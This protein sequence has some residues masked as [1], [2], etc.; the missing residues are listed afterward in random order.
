MASLNVWMNGERVGEWGTLRGGNPF[1]R[2]AKS[3][4]DSSRARA[5]SISL[6]L[7]ADLE[8][9]GE[10]VEN[11]FENLL[12]DNPEIRRRIRT[13]FKTSSSST[14][15][16]LAAI[17]R[18]CAG[19]VQLV[20]PNEEPTGWNRI[21]AELLTD[22]EV[23]T[24]LREVTAGTSLRRD[25]EDDFRMSLAGAQEKTAFLGMAGKWFRPRHATPTTHIFKL[26]L[27]VIGGFRGDFSD[28]VE[29]EWLCGKILH[30]L[31]LPVAES[32][33]GTFGEQRVL[34]VKRFDRR[35][36]GVAE[37]AERN[38]QYKPSADHW[39]ARLP[40]EDFCQA[41]GR[42]STRKY[43]AD[44]GP[45]IAEILTLL[46]FSANAASDQAN[47]VLAQ[48]TFWLLAA[49]DGHGKNF[50]LHHGVGGAYEMTP[51]YDVLSAWPVIGHGKNELPLEKAK[52]A[53]ALRS[54]NAHYR[55][56]EIQT[57][58]WEALAR[59]AGVMGLWERMQEHV[60]SVE[61]ALGRVQGL[62]PA[63]FS[64]RVFATICSGVR[65]Q[66]RRFQAAIA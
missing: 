19:A 18:D 4:A 33:I 13:R 43:E 50:S 28:S 48:L 55:I 54:E 65:S 62:L 66:V 38:D 35:W 60:D 2:Y 41:T 49:T 63:D 6:P 25:E 52:L 29:N 56:S 40:Q 17:G 5:L 10:A 22:E 53:M 7:T 36:I 42:P 8:L 24:A 37:G 64:E 3:W 51:F 26:P 45:S 21:D 12:P 15:D 14:F 39:I 31:G 23:D 44:G 46:A 20:P 11:Y 61:P 34:V 16:L 30:E 47:F 57:R 9:R 32:T 27:G 1:F 58:H 59:S